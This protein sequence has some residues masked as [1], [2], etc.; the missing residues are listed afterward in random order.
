VLDPTCTT[1]ACTF[2]LPAES[3]RTVDIKIF[4]ESLWSSATVAADRY[5]YG[6]A[7][8]LTS[9]S[10]TKG[11]PKGGNKITILVAMPATVTPDEVQRT[12]PAE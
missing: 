1:T 8:H 5:T 7:P 3:A 4:A 2:S 6:S 12:A 9:L 11:T 10:A